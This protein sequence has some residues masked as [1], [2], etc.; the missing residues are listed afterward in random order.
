MPQRR[1]L[2]KTVGIAATGL[3]AG[4]PSQG[5]SEPN[6]ASADTE[7]A[8]EQVTGAETDE[9]DE[10]G[11]SVG[12]M[13]AVATEWNV[14]R[15]RLYDAVALGR[16][17]APGAGAA[18]AQSVFARFEGASGEYGAHEQLEATSESAYEGFEDALGSV[19]SSLS[20]GDVSGAAS[21]ADKASGHLQT[22]QQA[23][24][25]QQATRVL[26]LLVLG[27]RA[28]N[29]AMA[30]TLGAFE[31]AATIAEETM[32]AFEDALVYSKIET[33]DAESYE[34]FENALAGIGSAAG[35]EDA[36]GVTEQARA[37]LDATV[38]GA[39]ALVQQEAVAGAG[40]LATMQARGWDAAALASAG[41]P[42]QA[43]AH[44]VTLSSYRARIADAD[45]LAANDAADAASTAV[46][47]V[48]AHFEGANAHDALEEADGEAY[49]AFEGGLEDLSS[50]IENGSADGIDSAVETVD[51]NLVTGIE[52]LVGGEDARAALESAFFRARIADAR[53]LYRLGDADSAATIV[54]DVFARFEENELGFH[55]TMEHESEDLYHRF[56]E[57]HLV[58]LQSAYENDD[59]GAVATHHDGVQQAL[60]D[61]EAALSTA[62]ASG[63][64]A[65]YM[66]GRA[67]DAAGLAAL[68][69]TDRAATVIQDTFAHFE[70]GAAGFHEALE[71]AD[72]EIYESFESTLSD[73]RAAAQDG[74][75]VT[76]AATAFNDEAIAAAYA[77]AGSAGGNG[78]AATA[79][80]QDV[81]ATFEEARVHEMLEEADHDAYEN[82]EAA[83]SDYSQGLTNGDG[84]PT[85]LADAT[86]TAQF[87][88]VGA[89]DSAP[90][91][92]GGHG[93]EESEETE[94]S[95]SGGPNVVE[96]VPDDADHVVDM[97]AV[98]Y[99]PEELTVSVGDKVAWEHVGGEPHSVTAVADEIPSDATYWA[100]GGFESE[101][102]AREGWENGEGAVQSG[103][104]YVHTFET[105]GEHGYVC[106]PHEAAGMVGTVIVEE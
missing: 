45:W 40:H 60:L 49:E 8:T 26:D 36:S 29:A 6:T 20:E 47:N 5:S 2:L 30:G 102:A 54:S 94:T 59:S 105:A 72:E 24:A 103:Q 11:V 31:A 74:G 104:S 100:S 15:A 19:Q 52:A 71:E 99:A 41:G 39:Y 46:E 68:S 43:Y 33:A 3:L 73:V 48:F 17:G 58:A 61:F 95:L 92:S 14:Y 7:A 51:T 85:V 69:E 82:F 66:I 22:A 64:E 63:A 98:A 90:S 84:D 78:E 38:T 12:P 1:D 23:A 101:S 79:I 4:C 70:S 67:F 25:G 28:S 53:E 77:I 93:S 81:F 10:S 106:I 96:G 32:T 80:V 42:G 89:V 37:A 75:D 18:V 16:A 27:S 87:A 35:S 97:E 21:A 91:G 50:A 9:G 62:V 56:E 65:D 76:S 57:E 55:E 86:R 88:V 83:L 13:T 44:T 34:A